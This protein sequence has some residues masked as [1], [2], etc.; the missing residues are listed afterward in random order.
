[1]KLILSV[2]VIESACFEFLN[3]DKIDGQWLKIKEIIN[4][5]INKNIKKESWKNYEL[6][7]NLKIDLV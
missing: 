2:F 4:H 7:L 5:K 3:K 6:K 1:M